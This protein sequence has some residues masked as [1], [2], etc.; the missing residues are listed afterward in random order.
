MYCFSTALK[1]QTLIIRPVNLI[2]VIKNRKQR[3]KQ[4]TIMNRGPFQ[5][6]KKKISKKQTS[7]L[8]VSSFLNDHT[9]KN[10]MKHQLP[11]RAGKY[12][13]LVM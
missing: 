3:V 6:Y 2:I 5:D 7:L 11:T 8:Y 10:L 12:D 1:E 9:K 4:L 13:K